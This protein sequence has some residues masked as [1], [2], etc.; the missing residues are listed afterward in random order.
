MATATL[1][2]VP[3]EATEVSTVRQWMGLARAGAL[4]MVVF[5]VLLQAVAR[6]IIPPVLV[7]GLV[8]VAFTPYL[9]GERRRVGLAA[10]IFAGAA[11]LANLPIILDDLSHPESAPAFILQL[12]ST[13]G[14][15]LVIVGGVS[16]FLRRPLGMLRPL[17]LA[18]VGVFLAGTF[19][20]VAIAASTDSV[21][22]QPGDVRVTAQQLMWDPEA[23][24]VDTAATGI[25]IDN[26]DG[27]RHTFTI[28][29]LG[30]D[31]EVPG[32]KARR[33]DL[34][35]PPGTYQ[36][37]CTVPGHESMTGTLTING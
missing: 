20:A 35:A 27:T 13:V 33:I 19:G 7:I 25:W 24:V 32:L 1:E 4:V 18:A 26:K 22:A 29:E 30:I 8:F 31:V 14:V 28:T 3:E 2:R 11:Y 36:I 23:V 15:L 16:A 12:L 34:D 9:N 21:S 17:A 10:A 5:A 37:I 6:S